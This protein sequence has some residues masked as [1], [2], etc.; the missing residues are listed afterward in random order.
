[1]QKEAEYIRLIYD[2]YIQGCGYRK[3][4]TYL[5]KQGVPTPSMIRRERELEEGRNTN[6]HVATVWSDGMVKEILDNDFY[7]GKMPM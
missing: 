6:R 3:I 5:T 7:I 4:S 2:L 1:M